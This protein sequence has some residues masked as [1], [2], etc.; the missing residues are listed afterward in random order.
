MKLTR[1]EL[2]NFRNF[3]HA[4]FDLM[5]PEGDRPLDVVLLVGD[6]GS[7]KTAFLQAVA[8]FFGSLSD[9]SGADPLTPADIRDSTDFMRLRVDWNDWTVDELGARSYQEFSLS[10]ELG[11]GSRAE[12]TGTY[13]WSNGPLVL[14]GG[15]PQVQLVRRWR[16]AGASP[17]TSCMIAA[18]DVYR[19]LPATKVAG[20]NVQNVIQ[21]AFS[22]AL[23]PTL[24]RTGSVEPRFTQLKQWIVNIDFLRAKAKAD[25][26]EAF[27]LWETLVGAL[28]KI[29]TP[30]TFAGVNDNFDVLF[31][32]P[33]GIMPIEALSDGFRS[34]FVIITDLLLR[35]SL[36]T[37]RKQDILYQEAVCLIDEIDAHLHPRWQELVIP[38]LRALFPSV[39]FIATTHSA[40]VVS[41]VEP[42]N[43]FQLSEVS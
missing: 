18:F 4:E 10:G 21:S 24:R 42:H 29:L 9:V 39:Q 2:D 35:L 38:G 11:Q 40:I 36:C 20:P 1:V 33:T 23:A 22:G 28:N 12:P 15:A 17:P 19:L 26:N 8:G 13:F 37:P 14:K 16:A 27:P 32:T 7:G 6:N 34:I 30:Y 3:G 25:R 43:V 5:A 41:T 31:H